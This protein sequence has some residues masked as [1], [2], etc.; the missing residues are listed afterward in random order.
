MPFEVSPVMVRV[1]GVMV[2]ERASVAIWS[3]V[4]RVRAFERECLVS[5]MPA[6]LLSPSQQP[7]Q[8]HRGDLRELS[9][10]HKNS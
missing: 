5:L 3:L 4:L 8:P 2:G 10:H 9:D 1:G 7:L 6:L